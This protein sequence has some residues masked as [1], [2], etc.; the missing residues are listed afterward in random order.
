MTNPA[1]PE[2][3]TQSSPHPLD[4]E[5]LYR[6]LLQQIRTGLAGVGDIALV[7]IH[8][9]GAWLAE[10]LAADLGLNDAARLCRSARSTATT[11]RRKGLR[12]DVKASQLPFDVDGAAIVLVDDVLYTGRTMRAAINELF[13]YGRPARII[14]AVLVDRG[15]RELPISADFLADTMVLGRATIAATSTG[16]RRPLFT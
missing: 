5:A 1:P 12:P 14:L 6:T 11:S 8:S 9:G 13:D 4:A 7:G 16:R 15:G 10:R 3:S 2:L